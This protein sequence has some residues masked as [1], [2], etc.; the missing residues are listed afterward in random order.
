MWCFHRRKQERVIRPCYVRNPNSWDPTLSLNDHKFTLPDIMP[1]IL[2]TLGMPDNLNRWNGC[3]V[4]F[5][6]KFCRPAA[7]SST[8]KGK[9]VS[10]SWT[11]NVILRCSSNRLAELPKGLLL[12][13]AQLQQLFTCKIQFELSMGALDEHEHC[14]TCCV[15]CAGA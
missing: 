1:F 3:C 12:D 9:D 14:A 4:S 11:F 10:R 8:C 2:Q 15:W 7:M 6:Q 13:E 5:C